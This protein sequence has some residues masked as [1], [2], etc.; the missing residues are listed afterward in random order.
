[1]KNLIN[2]S[3]K[4]LLFVTLL[5]IACSTAL[6]KENVQ[7]A[8]VNFANSSFENWNDSA[9]ITTLQEYVKDITNKS[10]KNFIPV[11]DR[12]AVFDMDGTLIGE[13]FPIYFEWMLFCHRVLK[14]KNYKATDEQIS[15]AGEVLLAARNKK[16]SPEL[17]A[18]KTRAYSEVFAGMTTDEFR[19][20][21]LNFLQTNADGFENLKLHEAYFR[22][23]VDI[24]NYLKIHDFTIYVVSGTDR[25]A[26]RMMIVDL[27]KLPKRH[28]IGSDWFTKG[29]NQADHKYQ[30]YQLHKDEKLI[31]D[32]KLIMINNVM[33]KAIQISQEIGQK[34]VLAFG[35]TS[36]DFSMFTY[37]TYQNKYPA[38]AFCL[39][40]DDD[41][42]EYAFA[43]KTKQL[44]DKCKQNSWHP[45]SMKNDF[46]T[47]YSQT[48]RKNS[49]HTPWMDAML[50]EYEKRTK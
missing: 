21:V 17:G 44:I 32:S 50:L 41:K 11:Q 6:A 27:L 24:V 37:T 25:E 30:M 34:P 31:R 16:I 33:G 42:R 14:D 19:Q 40:P 36:G 3:K 43:E 39:V 35:N 5:S 22:P 10:G 9:I 47:M 7:H 13:Q 38:K 18:K 45:I 28:I 4:I 49:K 20:Y 26:T 29:S 2:K 46:K 1:M 12:I 48:V 23:M 15:V 8:N